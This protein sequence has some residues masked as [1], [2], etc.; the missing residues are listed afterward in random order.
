MHCAVKDAH[1]KKIFEARNLV[2]FWCYHQGGL[3]CH[4][5]F[6]R[7]LTWKD[8]R[9]GDPIFSMFTITMKFCIFSIQNSLHN[10]KT[11]KTTSTEPN[12]DRT[13]DIRSNV[14]IFSGSYNNA[15]LYVY[16]CTSNRHV[17]LHFFA[18]RLPKTKNKI[19]FIIHHLTDYH[20]TGKPVSIGCCW[21]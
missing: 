7:K 3:K 21:L 20:K 15:N 4:M 13:F 12:Y 2:M 17:Y 6:I 11:S 10:S 8:G 19:H 16:T 14:I 1:F 9:T 5:S 18:L